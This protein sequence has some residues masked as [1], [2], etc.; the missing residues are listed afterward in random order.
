MSKHGFAALDD[1]DFRIL[2]LLQ[3]DCKIGIQK[4]SEKVG[5]GISTVHARVKALE[6]SKIIKQYTAVL[7]SVLLN[8]PTLALIFVTIRYRVPGQS[9][10]LSQKE[11]CQEIAKHPFV[12]EVYVLS[13]QYDVFL[14]VRTKDVEEMN[15]FIVDFLRELPA[16]ERTLTM[17]VM[18]S[19]L[20][21]QELRRLID[22]K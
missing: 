6:Q 9:D 21:T 7:D 15:R 22:E 16:V 14:K 12:Q 4:I 3:E 8:R 10:L 17:F 5:K 11:F 18:D 1:T 19:I 20:E 13:G 2:E